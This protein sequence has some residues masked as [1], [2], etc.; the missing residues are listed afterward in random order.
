MS[1]RFA[2]ALCHSL[3]LKTVALAVLATGC[4]MMQPYEHVR[5]L[6]K[7]EGMPRMRLAGGAEAA[8][9]EAERIRQ[10][11]YDNLENRAVVRNAAGVT[12]GVLSG[13]A[14]YN[15]I[16]PE[17]DA[18]A[19][20]VLRRSLR[21][22]AVLATLYGLRELFVD[23]AQEAIYAEGYRA[24]TCLMLQSAPLLM[25][26]STL[27]LAL[28]AVEGVQP[29]YAIADAGDMD[30]LRFALDA[31]ERRIG[32]VYSA[33]GELRV[34]ARLHA[35]GNKDLDAALKPVRD[36][37]AD[38]ERALGYANNA[39]SDGRTLVRTIEGSGRSLHARTA[40][41][42]GA[43]NDQL[44]KKLNFKDATAVLK[45]AQDIAGSVTRLGA[46]TATD[47]VTLT[48]SGPGALLRDGLLLAGPMSA[49]GDLLARPNDDS[50]RLE[51]VAA[52]AT[53]AASAAV[54]PATPKLASSARPAASTP[55]T[56]E[57]LK[58]YRNS[59]D[60]MVKEVQE[61][62]DKEKEQQLLQSL[63]DREKALRALAD[64]AARPLDTKRL[65]LAQL[66]EDLYAARRPVVQELQN[67]R[68]RTRE[69]LSTTDCRELAPLRVSP[70]EVLRAYRGDTVS[71]LIGQR[72]AG[73]NP[74]VAL[75][76]PQDEET[77]IKLSVDP[78]GGTGLHR[79]SLTVGKK[80]PKQN[81]KL[82]VT[83][84]RGVA[85]QT[86][87]IVAGQGDRASALAATPAASAA[88]APK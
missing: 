49:L 23:P 58:V 39:L 18:G 52:S 85:T 65:N 79:V 84:G 40:I 50:L 74:V 34:S 72:E 80:M 70:T 55:L 63:E 16:R 36:E 88:S 37:L 76:G 9:D 33:V 27:Q 42:T 66:K 71:Y 28:P 45:D 10:R 54:K 12:A 61:R 8:L 5:P 68:R 22:G 2:S 17:A 67:L 24:M 60:A 53:P 15:A 57:E 86:L 7:P 81:V 31:L 48:D 6:P 64:Q 47:Q 82:V 13:W 3:R 87:D 73:L 69:A 29:P 1:Y 19:D 30:R 26:E 44:Q 75:Q 25:S 35:R 62:V 38:V 59:I 83:D 20:G 11:F 51:L 43:V 56:L 4:S 14:V 77:G 41:I 46:D 21:I 78:L 32:M